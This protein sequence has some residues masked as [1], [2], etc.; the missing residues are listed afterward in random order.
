MSVR[1]W[2]S[3]D[4]VRR[5]SARVRSS[6]DWVRRISAR[7]RSSSGGSRGVGYTFMYT[8]ARLM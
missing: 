2:R 4:R 1:V 8:D 7:V 5:I 3:L 6:S